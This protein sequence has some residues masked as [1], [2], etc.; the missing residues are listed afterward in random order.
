[1]GCTLAP[2]TATSTNGGPLSQAWGH[3]RHGAG[4]L[5]ANKQLLLFS[6][7]HMHLQGKHV[8]MGLPAAL[9]GLDRRSTCPRRA[10]PML[11][12][13]PRWPRAQGKAGVPLGWRISR[14][15]RVQ[16]Q[17]SKPLPSPHVLLTILPLFLPIMLYS[18]VSS[19]SHP[20]P[21]RLTCLPP[22]MAR[23]ASPTPRCLLYIQEGSA[24]HLSSSVI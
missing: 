9:T 2:T 18:P 19:P 17:Q 15:L 23:P 24:D 1:M 20:A 3:A 22:T 7:Q 6:I 14:E 21:P 5:D 13:T 10:P 8:T 11:R 12:A 4:R 16:S